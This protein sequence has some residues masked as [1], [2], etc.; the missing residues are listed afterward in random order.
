M[1]QSN[2]MLEQALRLAELGYA[3]FPVAPGRKVPITS[4]GVYAATT[5]AALIRAWWQDTPAANI[6]VAC[7]GLVVLDLDP[8]H[9][10]DELAMRD[11]VNT[12]AVVVRTPRGGLHCYYSRPDGV[13]VRGSV[14]RV[15]DHVDI[16][17][18]GNYVIAP[19]SVVDGAP[20]AYLRGPVAVSACRTPPD[21]VVDRLR[22][23]YGAP[24]SSIAATAEEP[25]TRIAEGRRND[26]LTRMAG[27]LRHAGFG[28]EA[29]YAALAAE[30]AAVCDPP[31]SDDEVRTIAHSVSRYEPNCIAA[32]MTRNDFAAVFAAEDAVEDDLGDELDDQ[33]EPA[34]VDDYT[35][36]GFVDRLVAYTM[37]TAP[38]P[39]KP[40][41]F[42]GAVALTAALIGR[43]YIAPTG[44]AANLYI[45]LVGHSGCG[46]DYPRVVNK[47]ILGELE[48]A[49]M[50]LDSFASAEGLEDALLQTPAI[51]AQVDETST[52]LEASM[53]RRD[54]RY[55][56]IV[57]RLLTLY[58]SATSSYTLR[59][60][61]GRTTPQVIN[62]PSVTL[63]GCSTPEAY[64]GA[65]TDSIV[66]AGL[67]SRTLV[68]EAETAK[69][70]E[71][72]P[73]YR[74]PDTDLIATARMI[75]GREGDLADIHPA[76]TTV[77]M[78]PCG[79]RAL[80][81]L[82][83]REDEIRTA[84][85]GD[86]DKALSSRIAENAIKL[87]LV[88]AVSRNP[89]EP[90]IDGEALAWAQE[91]VVRR[92]RLLMRRRV[93]YARDTQFQAQMYR[94]LRYIREA[95]G[96]VSRTKVFRYGKLRAKDLDDVIDA[97]IQCRY[98]EAREI[99]GGGRPLTLYQ[100]YRPRRK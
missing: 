94:I 36:P 46:K 93:V 75:L 35:M 90:V 42:A 17:T 58:S 38:R 24:R 66:L 7:Q 100:P 68:I 31:L 76:I 61:A 67:G 54:A 9:P 44:T 16:R 48:R 78:T 28:G 87:A 4:Q 39:N 45:S 47:R 52:L 60:R 19:P 27:R 14:G 11:L 22:A 86:A 80:E 83:R 41:A 15:W 50:V 92:V 32:A 10:L 89:G 8:G 12:A 49:T 63:L 59:R 62:R 91:F 70:A 33:D 95:N 43:R 77:P 13:D 23:V 73:T 26:V 98:I 51:L 74:P 84:A 25:A 20:Y 96:P 79:E 57:H 21:W 97:L 85:N 64:Y 71:G 81:A 2:P 1:T 56:G 29:I 37:E 18:S 65:M 34:D 40:A 6:G 3:V 69:L 30:N 99:I 5:D 82:R 55:Q 72:R 53:S 88:Y